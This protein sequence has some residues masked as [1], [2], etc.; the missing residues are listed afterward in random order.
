MFDE[1]ISGLPRFLSPHP[2]IKEYVILRKTKV[3]KNI[4]KTFVD[5]ADFY[6]FAQSNAYGNKTILF[7]LLHRMIIQTFYI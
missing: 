7:S 2:S 4:T 3:N 5:S 6:I 1:V